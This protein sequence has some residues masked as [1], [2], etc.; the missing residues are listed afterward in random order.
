MTDFDQKVERAAECLGVELSTKP[1]PAV[2][3]SK[4]KLLSTMSALWKTAKSG[5]WRS[6]A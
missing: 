6:G 4:D 1:R 2:V 3:V 5:G